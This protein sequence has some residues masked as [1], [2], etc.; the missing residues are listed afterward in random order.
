MVLHMRFDASDATRSVIL[1]LMVAASSKL[2]WSGFGFRSSAPET[3]GAVE[4]SRP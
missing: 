3:D 4:A 2:I 1:D